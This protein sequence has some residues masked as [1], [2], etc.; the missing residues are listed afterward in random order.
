MSQDME[1][2][3]DVAQRNKHLVINHFEEFVNRK[4]I[5]AIDRNMR[6]DF[7]DHD[8]PGGKQ[9][10]IAEDRDMMAA[11][12]KLIPDLRVEVKDAIAEADKVVVRNVWTGTNSH[13]GERIEFHGFVLWRIESGRIAERWATVTPMQQEAARSLGW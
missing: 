6:A 7:R 5:T 13:T 1:P 12:Y 10:G 8:G 11:M 4:D 9:A 2:F 3:G